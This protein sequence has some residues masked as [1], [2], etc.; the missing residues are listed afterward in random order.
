[1]NILQILPELNVGGVETGTLDLSKSFVRLGHK[2][3]VISAGGELV[4]DLESLGAVHYQLPVDKKSIWNII[5]MVPLVE[6]II[7]KENIDIV[8]ARSRA[9]AWIA[10]W[11]CR[12]TK[13]VFITTCHGYYSRHLFSAV[14]GW[15]KR[16]IVPSNVIG[17]HM[18]S[19][20]GVP[21]DRIRLIPRSVDLEKFSEGGRAHEKK[22]VFNVGIIGRITPIKGHIDFI[23]GMAKVLK[24]IPSLKI[25]I[26]GDAPE[27]KGGYKEEIVLLVK[28][29]GIWKHTEFLGTQKDI[30]SIL[31]HL[32]VVV[33]ST[34]THEAF[35][36]V[37]VEA[38]ASGVPVV[39]TSV[40]GV[41]DII[42]D[43]KTGLL[44]PPFD[45]DA[46]AE[47]VIALYRDPAFAATLAGNAGIKV[48][49]L[50]SLDAM[51]SKTLGVYSEALNHKKILIIKI[52]SL[53]DIILSTAAIKAIR[54][55]FPAVPSGGK[56]GSR[57]TLSVLVGEE[58]RD[59]LLTCPYI[60]E[61]IVCNFKN[62]DKGL[63][64]ML[65][66]T[67]KLRKQ[68][69][70]IVIDLQNSRR[71]HSI[72]YL[73]LAPDRYGYDNKKFSFLL[74]HRVKDDSVPVDPVRHQ[75]KI[76]EDLGIRY[77]NPHLELWPTP[78]DEEYVRNLLSSAW[79]GPQQKLIGVN[80]SASRRWSS[81]MWPLEHCA[82]LCEELAKRD[83][84]IVV[85]GASIDIPL[86]QSLVNRVGQSKIINLCGKT[87]I[88]QLACL[89]R[90][91]AVY[92][93]GD[94][95]PLH[96]AASMDVPFIALFGPTDSRRH[97]PPAR[98]YR[99]IKKD[100]SCGPCYKSKC[101]QADCMRNISPAEVLKAVESLLSQ[102]NG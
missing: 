7:R 34:V 100:M 33:L 78:Q 23:K 55:Q 58:S 43:K 69:Y 101:R 10:Y 89:I 14:M 75:F 91:C 8:H 25:W 87:T 39:A 5:R 12:R 76:L 29:L 42:E 54:E 56:N 20:F 22:N 79:I 84:R 72:A 37:V 70:D 19:H 57:Y 98:R 24:A 52:S 2:A 18:T 66:L 6:E 17:H 88:N 67:A 94:S 73:T 38:Q 81:K 28:K 41:V 86:A 96:V 1:M 59:L 63:L 90:Q 53:G 85:T 44:V 4:K 30:P 74:N 15:G 62:K 3:V 49:D 32:D 16:V 50:Y 60:D 46:I 11:A 82:V 31:K 9:P 13:R 77:S 51:A 64:G 40:G 102:S 45:P 21:H 27:S 97:V 65:K 93:S 48:K 83:M 35:G 95:A 26:V 71:S 68:N 47:A 92:I 99:V 36:R 80:I 61:L